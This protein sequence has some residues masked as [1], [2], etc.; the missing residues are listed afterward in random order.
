MFYNLY[1]SPAEF[2]FDARSSNPQ[3]VRDDILLEDYNVK[4]LVNDFVAVIK[5]QLKGYRTNHIMI[6]MGGDFTFAAALA[7]FK[8][9]DKLLKY[10]NADGRLNVFYSTPSAY[11]EA[12]HAQNLTWEMKTDDFFPYADRPHSYMTGFYTSRPAL[13]RYIREQ[14]ALLQ[15]CKQ[16]ESVHGMTPAGAASFGLRE[17]MA[18]AQHHDSV[19]GTEQQHVAYDYAKRLSIGSAQCLA[20][21]AH[22]VS[23]LLKLPL[24]GVDATAE[25]GVFFC[26]E[27]NI[28]ICSVHS[29]APFSVLLYNPLGHARTSKV[30]VP[31]MQHSYTVAAETP[32][33]YG[34]VPVSDAVK[35]ARGNRSDI[36]NVLVLIAKLPPTTLVAFSIK[37]S[38]HLE[39]SHTEEVSISKD[40][41]FQR[42][43]DTDIV[44]I[45]NEYYSVNV[46]N[47]TG[48]LASIYDK[49]L[50]LQLALQQ[51][52]YWYESYNVSK[53]NDQP[54][55]AYIFRPKGSEP[56]PVSQDALC[57]ITVVK[58]PGVLEEVRQKCGDFVYQTIA[59][60]AGLNHIE[61]TFTVGPIPVADHRGKEVVSRFSSDLQ[62]AGIFYTDANG[63]EMQRRQRD[64]RN[65]WQP[66]MTIFE[67]VAGNFYPVNSRIALR[68]EK[69]G[70]QLTILT[71]SSQAGSSLVDGA[72]ELMVHR[73]LL[74]DDLRG[75]NEPL[76]ETGVSGKGLITRG[77]HYLQLAPIKSA[78]AMHR[79]L[80]QELLLPALVMFSDNAALEKQAGLV[81]NRGCD[82]D[83]APTQLPRNVH[84]LS[85]QRLD[86]DPKGNASSQR[87]VRFEHYFEVGEDTVLSRPAL[88]DVQEYLRSAF[89]ITITSMVEMTLS[90]NQEKL[91]EKR[92]HWK[93]AAQGIGQTPQLDSQRLPM[94]SWPKKQG[95]NDFVITLNPMEIRTYVITVQ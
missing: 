84:L 17:A 31:V 50:G 23:T 38:T 56:Y 33:T 55:G 65:T 5:K 91:Q 59:L 47:G 41:S 9:L 24:P 30:L 81:H 48:R 43:P 36:P 61:F 7:H 63:R 13:K 29:A 89:G 72:A 68:D 11:L 71:D 70:V 8:N 74:V 51:G 21:I 25:G 22:H 57:S 53:N 67:H 85:L 86:F 42:H 75:L 40:R 15:V 14:N 77:T 49:T 10:V 78:A 90:A 54:S 58:M 76:N 28:S 94:P 34:V 92:L 64:H 88:V 20:L 45:E 12:I 37:P 66:N 16:M 82:V 32:V 80:A 26:T 95:M 39:A 69:K 44:T 1:A 60:Y 93:V 18:V 4:T 87:L 19:S 46:S 52:F 62:T 79:P 2:N 83:A 35:H 27:M 3:V 6:P 73:R